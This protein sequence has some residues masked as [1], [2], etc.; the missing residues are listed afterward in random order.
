MVT[1]IL[2]EPL[3]ADA[4]PESVKRAHPY[5]YN[6][7]PPVA[8]V[9][10][11]EVAGD[12]GTAACSLHTAVASSVGTKRTNRLVVSDEEEEKEESIVPDPEPIEQTDSPAPIAIDDKKKKK[13]IQ[14]IVVAPLGDGLPKKVGPVSAEDLVDSKKDAVVE[15]SPAEY[16]TVHLSTTTPHGVSIIA[17][18]GGPS[19]SPTV[20]EDAEKKEQN[21]VSDAMSKCESPAAISEEPAIHPSSQ[22][23]KEVK[24]KKRIVPTHVSPAPM[25]SAQ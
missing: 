24:V 1:I 2:G 4:V 17:C 8:T 9:T 3:A 7:Q 16:P 5:L 12:K 25:P 20:A 19:S 6:Y 11:A 10:T 22:D 18:E 21:T 13:R 14:P 23:G 15:Y